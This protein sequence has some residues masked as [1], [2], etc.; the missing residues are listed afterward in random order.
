M[1]SYCIYPEGFPE[2][3]LGVLG[4]GVLDWP[5]SRPPPPNLDTVESRDDAA[6]GLTCWQQP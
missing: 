2:S 5:P 4:S 3:L 1:T 6:F